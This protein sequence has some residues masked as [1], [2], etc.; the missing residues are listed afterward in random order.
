VPTA[1]VTGA[2]GLVGSYIVGRLLTD[3][4]SVRAL[5]R[6]EAPELERQGAECVRG[7]VIDGASFT[8]AAAGRTHIFHC[9][10]TI[11][12]AGD[13][14]DYRRLNIG[15][16]ENAIIAAER[17]GARLCQ[18][19]SVAVYSSRYAGD[20]ENTLESSPLGPLPEH[21][22]YPRSKRVSE[23]RVMAAHSAGRI[24][25]TAVRPCVIYGRRDRQCVPRAA[26]MLRHGWA[27]LIGG[28]KSIMPVVHAANVADGAV[29]AATSDVAGGRAYNLANDFEV[30]VRDFFTLGGRGLGRRVR[31]I[32]IPLGLARAVFAVGLR[33][34]RLVAGGRASLVSSDSLSMIT[35]DNPYDSTLARRELGWTPHVR[36]EDGV[37][38]AFRWWREHR[39]A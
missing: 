20:S 28:G 25:A 6:G 32:P 39:G 35:R 14:E 23:E 34:M 37:P 8:R 17:S 27:P 18:L 12:Q 24:W 31:F 3:G 16:T 36:P 30:T 38:D 33:M 5:V 21:A 22:F 10:A 11:T 29:L 13:W 4:W 19:S 15:G 26:Q 2:T 1:L 7:D 9:A